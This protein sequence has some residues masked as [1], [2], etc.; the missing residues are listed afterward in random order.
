MILY[1]F[2]AIS[3]IIIPKFSGFNPQKISEL[4]QGILFEKQEKWLIEL[5]TLVGNYRGYSFEFN[6]KQLRDLISEAIRTRA[7]EIINCMQWEGGNGDGSSNL[8]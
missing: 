3:Q 4:F 1:Y 6:P 5:K 8:T 7:P 2:D